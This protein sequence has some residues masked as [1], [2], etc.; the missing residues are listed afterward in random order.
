LQGTNQGFQHNF[1]EMY[2][3]EDLRSRNAL[4]LQVGVSL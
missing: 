4:A 2:E 1:P 3:V